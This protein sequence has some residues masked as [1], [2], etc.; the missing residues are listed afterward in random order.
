VVARSEASALYFRL[1]PLKVRD[2]RLA[3]NKIEYFSKV[4]TF[5][6]KSPSKIRRTFLFV[7]GSFLRKA[8]LVL[9]GGALF[10]LNDP[11]RNKYQ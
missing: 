2:L 1:L 9:H 3:L 7:Q 8:R 5:E 11:W 4:S 10:Q 6:K